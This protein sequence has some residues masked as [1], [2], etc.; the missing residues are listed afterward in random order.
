MKGQWLLFALPAALISLI[1]LGFQAWE[2]TVHYGPPK[3]SNQKLNIPELAR[4]I[5]KN[6]NFTMH[7]MINTN[8][9][10]S[11]MQQRESPSNNREAIKEIRDGLFALAG[12]NYNEEIKSWVGSPLSFALIEDGMDKESRGWLLALSS[13]NKKKLTEFIHNFWL[14]R[15]S[16]GY[17]AEIESMNNIQV[18][19]KYFIDKSM[20]YVEN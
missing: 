12:L 10:P 9:L 19:S 13:N 2:T 6:S 8:Q 17:K 11:V 16:S 1:I 3:L 15:Q 4:F 20:T 14:E 18:N 5:P 7:L